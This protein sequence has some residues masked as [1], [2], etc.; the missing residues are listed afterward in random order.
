MI[1]FFMTVLIYGFHLVSAYFTKNRYIG[2]PYE[3]SCVFVQ[4]IAKYKVFK[5]SHLCCVTLVPVLAYFEQY[6]C[7][8]NFSG[9][10]IQSDTMNGT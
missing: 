1:A 9:L 10:S 6:Q 7:C 5:A 4:T 2:R 3:K 8:V